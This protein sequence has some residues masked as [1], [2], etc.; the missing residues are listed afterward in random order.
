MDTSGLRKCSSK[1][2]LRLVKISELLGKLISVIQSV[3]TLEI[4]HLLQGGKAPQI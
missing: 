1:W 4:A 3:N 2:I